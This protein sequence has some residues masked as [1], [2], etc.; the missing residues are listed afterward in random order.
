VRLRNRSVCLTSRLRLEPLLLRNRQ[1][2]VSTAERVLPYIPERA[3]R[4]GLARLLSRAPA[5]WGWSSESERRRYTQLSYRQAFPDGDCDAF[6]SDLIVA[7]AAGLATSIAYLSQSGLQ[8][9]SNLVVRSPSISVDDGT[10]CVVAYLHYSIDPLVQLAL[11]SANPAHDFRWVVFPVQSSEE[12]R[13]EDERALLLVNAEVEPTI[14]TRFLSVTDARWLLAAL[15]HVR[16]GGSLFIA[17]DTALDSRRA[18]LASLK[19]GKTTMP[20][21]AALEVLTRGCEARLIFAWPHQLQPHRW[22]VRHTE[23]G[24]VSELAA[25]ASGWIA[26]HPTLWA[27][28]PY[29]TWRHKPSDMREAVGMGSR[30]APTNRP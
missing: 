16:V 22:I 24:D 23:C 28:W 4:A 20:V 10:P 17:V 2:L 7:R 25:V 9:R 26:A 27:G 3:R 11:L 5:L 18:R 1:S 14:A 29:I 19:I 12:L 13:W 8:R 21:S 30:H 6:M 15:R